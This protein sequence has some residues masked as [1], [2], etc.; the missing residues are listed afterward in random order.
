MKQ[1]T[2]GLSIAGMAVVAIVGIV[3]LVWRLSL[4]K[5]P[6]PTGPLKPLAAWTDDLVLQTDEPP[7]GWM[8]TGVRA[9]D[10]LG[11]DHVYG[12]ATHPQNPPGTALSVETI[13]YTTTELA[14]QAYPQMR[15][16]FFPPAYADAWK[17]YPELE[18]Q[19]HADEYKTQCLPG[20]QFNGSH[21]KACS[22]L[23]R[24]QNVIVF[25]NGIVLPDNIL[26]M[27]GF[28]KML[29]SVDRRVAWVMSQ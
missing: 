11:L 13:I 14:K 8:V 25:V 6:D 10:S 12:L 27:S 5:L 3:F 18:I 17:T 16:K 4:P 24:Y 22:S 19:S 21:N 15:D 23:A 28:H 7:I 9:K 29:E 26:T 2:S 1:S 20:E